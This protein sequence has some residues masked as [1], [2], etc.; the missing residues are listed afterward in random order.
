MEELLAGSLPGS[1]SAGVSAHVHLLRLG[2][3]PSFYNPDNPPEVAIGH[4][5]PGNPSLETLSDDSRL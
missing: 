2:P 5:D 4:T 1:R 3:S